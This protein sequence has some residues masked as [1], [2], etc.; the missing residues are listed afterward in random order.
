MLSARRNN[1]LTAVVAEPAQAQPLRW[2][3]ASASGT[4]EVLVMAGREQRP[5][6]AFRTAEA[7]ELLWAASLDAERPAWC[8]NSCGS[9]RWPAPLQPS[10]GGAPCSSTMAQK[11]RWFRPTRASRHA[12]PRHCCATYRTPIRWKSAAA[13]LGGQQSCTGRCPVSG[14]PDPPQLELTA[15]QRD[16]QLQGSLLWATIVPSPPWAAVTPLAGS[17]DGPPGHSAASGSVANW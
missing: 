5:A 12:G 4:G 14:C 11:P 16:N 17:T 1:W 3:L 7:S 10:G 13:F 8:P 6:P 2:G 15:T 9:H